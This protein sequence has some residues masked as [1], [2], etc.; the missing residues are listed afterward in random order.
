MHVYVFSRRKIF[1]VTVLIEVLLSKR[2]KLPCFF[3][4]AVYLLVLC[5]F[6]RAYFIIG[7][8]AAIVTKQRIEIINAATVFKISELL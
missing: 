6:A 3:C 2:Y 5:L 7:L 8:W 1:G 4:V